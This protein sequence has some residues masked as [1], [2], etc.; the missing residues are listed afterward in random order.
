MMT[1]EVYY[2]VLKAMLVFIELHL[3][4]VDKLGNNGLLF[5]NYRIKT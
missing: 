2:I 1:E 3:N 4:F 5:F